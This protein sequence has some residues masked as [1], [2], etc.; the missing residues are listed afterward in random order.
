MANRRSFVS[1]YPIELQLHY[2]S[3]ELASV[4]GYGRTQRINSKWV[5]FA[6]DRDLQVGLRVR[7]VLPWP[8]QLPDGTRIS[9][10]M[11]GQIIRSISCQVEARVSRHEFRTLGTASEVFIAGLLIRN[12]S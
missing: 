2:D 6:S 4:Q 10:W 3:P 1:N 12:L 5:E 8:A 7:L 11:Y 9:L